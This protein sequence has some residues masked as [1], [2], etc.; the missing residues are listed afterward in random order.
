MAQKRRTLGALSEA[1]QDAAQL[2]KSPEAGRHI[3]TDTE[4][5]TQ[6]W[7]DLVQRLEDCS[8]QVTAECLS[9]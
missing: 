8:N 4:E 2:L 1:G 6:R 9:V 3:E 7:D 5:L